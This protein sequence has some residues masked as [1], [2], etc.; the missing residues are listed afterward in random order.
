MKKVLITGKNGG[1]SIAVSDYLDQKDDYTAERI[2]LRDNH[3]LDEDLVM[4]TRPGVTMLAASMRA[5]RTT[6]QYAGVMP[7]W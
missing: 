5:L 1:L 2:S 4:W 6:G 3:F 7:T